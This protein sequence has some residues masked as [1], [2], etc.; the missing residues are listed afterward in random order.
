MG[1]K[2]CNYL[3][4]TNYPLQEVYVEDYVYKIEGNLYKQQG[5]KQIYQ[6]VPVVNINNYMNFYKRVSLSQKQYK[7]NQTLKTLAGVSAGV[8]TVSLFFG[9]IGWIIGGIT[10]VTATA[11]TA[12]AYN[13]VHNEATWWG[14]EGY[15]QKD[16]TLEYSL[17]N[18]CSKLIQYDEIE[19]NDNNNT[20][21]LTAAHFYYT[22]SENDYD[23]YLA[24]HEKH[25]D[26]YFNKYSKFIP[27]YQYIQAHKD[28]YYYKS[29][30]LR[31]LEPAD[32]IN[33]NDEYLVL[34]YSSTKTGDS[35]HYFN[36]IFEETFANEIKE[37]RINNVS[38]Y[39][40]EILSDSFSFNDFKNVQNKTLEEVLKQQFIFNSDGHKKYSLKL[41]GDNDLYMVIFHK[42]DYDKLTVDS[43]NQIEDLLKQHSYTFYNQSNDKIF[44]PFDVDNF[45][46]GFY[47]PASEEELTVSDLEDAQ[48]FNKDRKYYLV[49]NDSIINCP[50]ITQ[51]IQKGNL[52]YYYKDQQKKF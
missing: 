41:A 11:L 42:E 35:K 37:G 12:I 38:H 14:N 51:I 26:H 3:Y 8:G 4:T 18:L 5:D 50:T 29:S 48:A 49:Q 22:T 7:T 24:S 43:N 28:T 46:E 19:Y 32:Q 33:I 9:P 45:V 17:K 30:Y 1:V 16:I 40:F 52:Y 34:I 39:I 23:D 36:G 27:H 2:I 47:L 44:S 6:P 31:L 10:W 15:T 13:Q 21:T 25:G 20:C